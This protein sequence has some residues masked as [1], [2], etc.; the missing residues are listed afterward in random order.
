MPTYKN[1]GGKDW[2]AGEETTGSLTEA[3]KAVI[4]LDPLDALFK[5]HDL[6]YDAANKLD[7]LA[8]A[9]AVLVAD[10]ILLEGMKSPDSS[11]LDDNGQ[12]YQLAAIAA[13]Q[14]KIFL[15]IYMVNEA[16]KLEALSDLFNRAKIWTWP[17]DPIILD[18]GSDGLETM[19]LSGSTAYF[20][21]DGDGV[22]SKSGWGGQDDAL[23]VWDRNSN[24]SIDS[25]AE[26]L[27]DFTPLPNGSLA[28]NG[29]AALAA[30][31]SNDDGILD[32]SDPAFAELK[33][34]RDTSQDGHSGQGELI[35]LAE[36]G[37]VAPN[38]ANTL[39]NQ[40]LANGC[41]RV[42]AQ[43]RGTH[44][45]TPCGCNTLS[46]EGSF[47]RADSGMTFV[48]RHGKRLENLT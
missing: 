4:S 13:F 48:P 21:F 20:D 17:R 3:Q 36:A 1:W 29:F 16:G 44:R 41:G 27:G 24:G 34:W 47:S 10:I 28:P 30:L 40:T 14:N 35:S 18:L 46:R 42:A 22:L 45:R 39:K 23:L 6:A 12:Q 5:Q 31:D 7:P 25:G 26:L 15:D 9:L 32:A 11:L 2:S 19:G 8:E 38:L 33:L 37:I 43:Q